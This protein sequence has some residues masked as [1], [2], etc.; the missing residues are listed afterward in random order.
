MKRLLCI[1]GSMNPGGAETFLMKI[2]RSLDRSKYQ[3]DFCVSID[4]PGAYDQEIEALGGKIFHT[5]PKSSGMIKSFKSIVKIVSDN[6]YEYVL[7]VSQHSLSGLELLA[8]KLG[9]AKR[10]AY[11]SSNTQTGGGKVN[12]ILHKLFLPITIFVPDVKIAPST[13][14]AQ[15]MFGKSSVRK[16]NAM[17]L[18]NGL[19]TDLYSFDY[20]AR[21]FYRKE[22][23]I[24][25]KFVI[26]HIGR[27]SKQ[28]NHIKLL[29]ILKKILELNNK[30]I[31]VLVGQGELEDLIKSTAIEMGLDDSV[32]FLGVRSDVPK[33]LSAFDV[34]L[35]PSLFEGMP[36]TVLEAQTNG[37][38]CV[39]S[40]TITQEVKVTSRVVMVPLSA[41]ADSWA[42]S[43]LETAKMNIDRQSASK[44]MF[45]KG[46]DISNNTKLF[47][48]LIFGV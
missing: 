34:F 10:V 46:Y 18:P 8:A 15:F 43:V 28:K 31:L 30:A 1:V 17:I 32:R 47:E 5:T 41:S 24:E 21:E 3:M 6:N 40:N 35:F 29:E 36:N 4:K 20:H 48:Q 27:F 44:E 25:D 13:E 33:L 39:V 9:G 11:R 37:L 14:A 22:L 38:P 26:G 12:R 16:G 2:Y 23:N 19:D 7:R 45:Q 42:N